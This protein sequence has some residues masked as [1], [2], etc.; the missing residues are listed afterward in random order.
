MILQDKW[1]DI[2]IKKEGLMGTS[3]VAIKNIK[4]DIIIA[5]YPGEMK[6]GKIARKYIKKTEKDKTINT[7][8][9]LL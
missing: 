7:S 5:R 8:F 9:F 2:M 6:A 3:I 1:D 4:K